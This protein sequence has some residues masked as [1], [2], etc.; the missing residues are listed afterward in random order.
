MDLIL[1]QVLGL[2]TQYETVWGCLVGK[3]LMAEQVQGDTCRQLL[4]QTPAP[5]LSQPI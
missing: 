3:I 2:A 5:G 4:G 1:V